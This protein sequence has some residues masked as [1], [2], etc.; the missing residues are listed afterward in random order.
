VAF[1]ISA[2]DSIA[3]GAAFGTRLSP[4]HFLPTVAATSTSSQFSVLPPRRRAKNALHYVLKYIG[5]R[6]VAPW[7]RTGRHRVI[8]RNLKPRPSRSFVGEAVGLDTANAAR[9]YIHLYSSDR[10][11]LA[12]SPD[13]IQRG[14]NH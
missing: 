1:L 2:A 14:G 10:D 9:D 13:R 3:I 6:A 5:P 12:A 11:T 8:G 4:I 7:R